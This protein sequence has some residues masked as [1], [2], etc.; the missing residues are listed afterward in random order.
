MKIFVTGATGFIGSYLVREALAG[1]HEVTAT[2]RSSS[3][4]PVLYMH[5]EPVWLN[6]DL[7]SITVDDIIGFDVVIH[8][9][10]AGVSPRQASWSELIDV[11]VVGAANL[12]AT[13]HKAGIRR[14]VVAGTCHEYG[15]SANRYRAIPASAA[16][17]P[18]TPYGAS[19]AAAFQLISAYARCNSLALYYGR[20]FNAYGEGQY[21]GSFWPQLRLAALSGNDFEMTEGSQVRDFIQVERV[22]SALLNAATCADLTPGFPCVENIG[23]G[24]P[25]TLLEFA[26]SEWLRLGA[27]GRILPGSLKSR[28]GD[29]HHLAPQV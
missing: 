1:K 16:L 9:A 19:K 15:E 4:R 11:N 28:A 8:L 7:N 6:R 14:F 21:S 26:K 25:A 18:L 29:L 5:K 23:S 24:I 3:S 22:A 20:I 10:T 17:E 2:R 13:A 12:V 27:T